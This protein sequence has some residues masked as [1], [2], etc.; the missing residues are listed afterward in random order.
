M[1]TSTVVAA[2]LLHDNKVLIARRK[3]DDDNG[4]LWEF[5]GGTVH[6]GESPASCLQREIR[7]ELGI[8][9]IVR[10][11]FITA[12]HDGSTARIKLITYLA[13]PQSLAIK[14]LDHDEIR[15]VAIAD[16][17]DYSFTPA[18]KA[19]VSALLKQTRL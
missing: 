6:E 15:W 1:H 3:A 9:I 19:V 10:R 11:Q 5:P 4:G 13:E 14:A 16:L 18:D 2:V 17:A 8:A 7:E 12:T